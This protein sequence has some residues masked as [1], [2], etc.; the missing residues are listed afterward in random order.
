ML[1][2]LVGNAIKFTQQG[3]VVLLIERSDKPAENGR[4]RL[5]FSVSDTGIG[6]PEEKQR[7]IFEAFS[8]ADASTTR[9]Y[10][11]TGLGLTICSRLVKLMG[12]EIGVQSE[13]GRGSTFHFT[14]ELAAGTGATTREAPARKEKL[15]GLPVLIVDD[16]ATNRHI[17]EAMLTSW[18]MLPQTASSAAVALEL[19]N[20][21]A[22]SGAPF[23]LVLTDCHMPGG[24]GF[25]LVERIR[26]TPSLA[27]ASI[28]M[29]TSDGYHS[30]AR[31][32]REIGITKHLIKPIK[33]S[34][35]LAALCGLLQPDVAV[36]KTRASSGAS[37]RQ[38]AT[39]LKVLLAEDNLVNQRLAVRMI[40]KLGHTVTVAGNG[41]EALARLNEQS[42]DLVLMDVQ[43]PE[44]DGFAV[45]AVIRAQ[46]R[47]GDAHLPIIA[48]TAHAM[49]GDRQTCL[50]A[51]MDAYIPKPIDYE[52]LKRAIGTV[53]RGEPVAL[54]S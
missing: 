34:E 49:S 33:Q 18:E 25:E 32:C 14:A 21:A 22:A 2:N 46:E 28:M 47:D 15:R 43:M 20:R 39:A 36:T 6:I 50:D 48:L 52:Q 29:L 38:H 12:G 3:E 27:A 30:S 24:D 7:L 44:M 53:M 37:D 4:V 16:N 5:K 51:G 19:M 35:L 41:L 26:T 40:E 1:I 45:T 42:F 13:P 31:R 11:G 8:Q 10:G 17:L 9:R 23:R 54:H